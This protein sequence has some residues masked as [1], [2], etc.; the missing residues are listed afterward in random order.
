[1]RFGMR[2][3]EGKRAPIT[4][5]GLI[6]KALFGE[7]GA[8]VIMEKR[9]IRFGLDS[10]FDQI[11]SC[12]PVAGLI[13]DQAEQ[14]QGVGMS[15]GD[16]KYLPVKPIGLN[17]PAGLMMLD[18][19]RKQFRDISRRAVGEG[20]GRTVL[21]WFHYQGFSIGEES[22]ITNWKILINTY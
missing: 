2:G 3:I 17:Q 1:M 9:G 20:F 13:S 8:K 14:M 15:R 6:Q 11:D 7:N 10:V 18:S 19:L 22:T 16:G 21:V 12:L 4:G 5:Y